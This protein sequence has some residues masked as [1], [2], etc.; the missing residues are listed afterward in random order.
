M[1]YFS[2]QQT[3]RRTFLDGLLTSMLGLLIVGCGQDGLQQEN[4]RLV[5]QVLATTTHLADLA[6]QIGGDK[7]A[8]SSL[9]SPGVDP[10]SFRAS[11]HDIN[12]LHRADLVL[13]HGFALEG[14]I[15]QVLEG[16]KKTCH[17]YFSP[18]EKVSSSSLIYSGETNQSI[19]P[20]LW[21]SPDIWISCARALSDQLTKVLPEYKENFQGNL[22]AFKKTVRQ[23][24]QWGQSL[25]LSIAEP[26]RVLITSHDAFQYFGQHF[27][28]KVV[29]LQGI[30]TLVE[31]GLADRANLVDFIRRHQSPALFVESSVNPKALE[32]IAKESGAVIGGTLFSDA[33]GAE[34]QTVPGIDGKPL[35]TATWQGMM[36]HNLTTIARALNRQL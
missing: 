32:E 29:G 8:V 22:E 26:Q 7:I 36:V 23:V 15:A 6:R 34:D 1:K 27:K 35:S 14:K 4:E 10:H 13:Y 24:D 9:M 21:F 18:C 16:A 3:L 30:N 2:I 11:A 25:M 17:A 33:L 31:A 12:R 19:D 5:L 28:V 20:H